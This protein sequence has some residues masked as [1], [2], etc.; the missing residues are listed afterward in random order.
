MAKLGFHSLSDSSKSWDYLQCK[1]PLYMHVTYLFSIMMEIGQGVLSPK[2][3]LTDW[4]LPSLRSLLAT[5]FSQMYWWKGY[6]KMNSLSY[7]SWLHEHLIFNL[8]FPTK[9][10]RDCILKGK[11]LFLIQ[12]NL[13]QGLIRSEKLLNILLENI[14]F[15]KWKDGSVGEAGF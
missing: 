3:S 8:L 7:N 12:H 4:M 2:P 5:V 6:Y 9:I 11:V 13:Q 14:L 1:I 15:C 10:F